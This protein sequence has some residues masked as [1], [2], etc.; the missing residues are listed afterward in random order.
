MFSVQVLLK[1]RETY[2]V[3]V[4]EFTIGLVLFLDGVICEMNN[5]IVDIFQ[6]KLF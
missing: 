5:T 1:V 2:F 6:S 4:F 3:A